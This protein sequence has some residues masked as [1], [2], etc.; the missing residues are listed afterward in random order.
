[1]QMRKRN[2]T[3]F[4]D[5]TPAIPLRSPGQD[6]R[7]ILQPISAFLQVESEHSETSEVDRCAA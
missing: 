3:G 1:M 5:R 7:V 4:A 2:G 6:V